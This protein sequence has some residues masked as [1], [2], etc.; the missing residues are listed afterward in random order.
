MTPCH[1]LLLLLL[2]MILQFT[3][4]LNAPLPT[5]A[6]ILPA[7]STPSSRRYLLALSTAT[8]SSL[9]VPS[10]TQAASPADN[11]APL[12]YSYLPSPINVRIGTTLFDYETIYPKQFITYLSRFLLSFDPTCQRWWFNQASYIPRTATTDEVNL[13]RL[14]QFGEFAASVEIGLRP[15]TTTIAEQSGPNRL[16]D[17]LLTRFCPPVGTA[18][19]STV[20]IAGNA[21]AT[22]T[23]KK[24]EREKREA[25]RQICLLFGL[26]KKDQV[27]R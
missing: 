18:P 16:M 7:P 26:M 14:Q 13:M 23:Q 19:T 27:R 1:L 12:P 15:Y 22:P 10:I 2:S 17:S 21:I 9:I 8:L 4:P 3:S 5:L 25:R 6:T 11:K 20:S 24:R